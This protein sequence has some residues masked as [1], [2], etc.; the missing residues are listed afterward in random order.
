MLKK[1]ILTTSIL[2]PMVL[3]AILYGSTVIVDIIS[4]IIL[5]IAALEW[6]KLIG[7]HQFWVHL[8]IVVFIVSSCI[9]FKI[10]NFPIIACC[11]FAALW[12]VGSFLVIAMYPRGQILWANPW[13]GVGL[14]WILFVPTWLSLD[15]LHAAKNFGPI[16]VVFLCC[17]VWVADSGAYFTGKLWGKKKLIEKVSAG[18]T[19]VGVFGAFISTFIFVILF[20]NFWFKEQKIAMLLALG[21]VVVVA[22]ILGDLTESLFKRICGVKDSGNLLPGHGGVLDRIDGLLAAVPTFMVSIN[23]F[24][25]FIGKG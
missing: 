5:L 22:S 9:L 3:C 10:M 6:N 7:V 21:T 2:L 17:L 24:S 18:K 25:K 14:S 11:F 19:W 23:F 8:L 12:W 16:W 1:R 4:A 20:A 15:W 13:I